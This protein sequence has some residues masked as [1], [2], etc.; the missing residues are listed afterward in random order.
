M[1]YGHQM[2]RTGLIVRCNNCC[3]YAENRSVK[4]TEVCHKI[5]EDGPNATRGGGALQRLW[6]LRKGRH[7]K[8]GVY[9]GPPSAECH[10]LGVAEGGGDRG[11]TRLAGSAGAS[12]VATIAA[13]KRNALRMMVRLEEAARR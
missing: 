6:Q 2:M 4:L 9:V 8:T 13:K 1:A 7:P 12:Y 11:G 5:E 3:T 10:R